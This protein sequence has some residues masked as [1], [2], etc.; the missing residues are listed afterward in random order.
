MS[1]LANETG[2]LMP[3]APSFG[4]HKETGTVF[5]HYTATIPTYFQLLQT[6]P[7]CQPAGSTESSTQDFP[8]QLLAWQ[9]GT[10]NTQ[11]EEGQ[12]PLYSR[13]QISTW[14]NSVHHGQPAQVAEGTA[15]PGFSIPGIAHHLQ[16]NLLSQEITTHLMSGRE[17]VSLTGQSKYYSNISVCLGRDRTRLL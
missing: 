2:S 14:H 4:H 7:C 10:E 3:S 9:S 6:H 5:K 12:K 13:S 1:P 15:M 16:G 8:L 17:G 11:E